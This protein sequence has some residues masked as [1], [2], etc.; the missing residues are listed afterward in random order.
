VN[1][2]RVSATMAA[3][4]LGAALLVGQPVA[5]VVGFGLLGAGLS[6]IAPQV[7]SAAGNRDP[8]RAGRALS[9]VVSIGYVGFLVGPILIGAASTQVGLPT[10]L[11]IP[12]VL[13]L[14]VAACAPVLRPRRDHA[15]I[16]AAREPAGA[17]E[18]VSR[19]PH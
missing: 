16:P 14:F 13:A 6:G 11:A 7:F 12:A 4:G 8:A 19:R 3:L 17:G 18:P 9:L 5:G 1:L 10:A 15:P 2:V